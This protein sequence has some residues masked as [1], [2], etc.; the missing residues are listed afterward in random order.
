MANCE[1]IE[2][3]RLSFK[4]LR[5]GEYG[6]LRVLEASNVCKTLQRLHLGFVND[7]GLLMMA[8]KL[9]ANNY[10]TT[11]EFDEENTGEL[12]AKWTEEAMKRFAG[13]L[14]ENTEIE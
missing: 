9:A 2:L 11:I 14:K 13:M 5:L 3:Q 10:L 1:H 12:T 8:D 6:L 4:N 7:A